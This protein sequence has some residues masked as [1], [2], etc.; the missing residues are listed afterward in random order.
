[1]FS[2]P[3]SLQIKPKSG[4]LSCVL[5][6]HPPSAGL[7]GRAWGKKAPRGGEGER[8]GDAVA[9]AAAAAAAASTA[10][11]AWCI[12]LPPS[13]LPPSRSGPHS[14]LTRART[15]IP[16]LLAR[17]TPPRGELR[18]ERCGRQQEGAGPWRAGGPGKY[19]PAQAAPAAATEAAA[20]VSRVPRPARRRTGNAAASALL[21]FNSN[22]HR[23]RLPSPRARRRRAPGPPSPPPHLILP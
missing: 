11:S 10:A 12:L 1:M 6:L 8:G 19:D 5:K 18:R 23:R 4:S 22:C 20:H 16:T 2:F 14:A 17:P 9:G 21:A 3:F 13:L 7:Q 15:H